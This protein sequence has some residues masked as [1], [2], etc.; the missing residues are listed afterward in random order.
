MKII[1]NLIKNH[2]Q[3]LTI[4]LFYFV[5]NLWIFDFAG[6]SADAGTH[7]LLG[8]FYHD[9]IIDWF[10]NP[11][12]SFDK[13][14]NY[15][16]TYLTYY[17]KLTVYYPPFFHLLITFSYFIFGVSF[18]SARMVELSFSILS[19]LSVYL[20]GKELFD[21]KVGLLS[22]IILMTSP[23]FV[24]WSRDILIDVP[25][26]FFFSITTFFYLR[27]LR[28]KDTRFFIL[29]IIT[30]S[31]GVLTKWQSLL[32]FPI[33]FLYILFVYRKKLKQLILAFILTA[34]IICP[35]LFVSYKIDSFSLQYRAGTLTG[36]SMNFPQWNELR[37][38]TYYIEAL[39]FDQFFFPFSLLIFFSFIYYLF[40]GKK[41]RKFILI[42]ILIF[43]LFFVYYSDKRARFTMP[44]LPIFSIVFSA[45]FFNFIKQYKKFA[46]PLL[47]LLIFLI[48]AQSY[49]SFSL[50]PHF[51]EPVDD[52]ISDT[53]EPNSN[54]L[55]SAYSPNVHDSIFAYTL[56]KHDREFMVRYFRYCSVSNISSLEKY[57]VK[58]V[59]IAE[60]HVST[61]DKFANVVYDNLDLFEKVEEYKLEDETFLVF[62]YREFQPSQSKCNFVCFPG[63][64]ICSEYDKPADALK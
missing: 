8:L 50:L 25:L 39:L 58:Y 2:W 16:I 56:A 21:K 31:L 6:P 61:L 52:I 46:K 47:G 20:L 30:G 15:G 18:F 54:I 64:T 53:F 44:Y 27:W 60:P 5:F 38:W 12:F 14:Y 3:I 57:G 33:L 7:S 59:I 23:L 32:M 13:I 36:E 28:K 37:G 1:N 48:L 51:N 45:V 62:R 55:V 35:Y 19:L 34:L 9:L 22:T 29:S 41:H 24:F 49:Y 11:T 26:I 42:W 4:I 40:K 10:K 63:E 43:Y 17:P